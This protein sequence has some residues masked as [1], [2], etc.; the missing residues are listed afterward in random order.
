MKIPLP[1]RFCWLAISVTLWLT[2]LV[3]SAASDYAVV[4]SAPTAYANQVA[5]IYRLKTYFPELLDQVY[6][7][8]LP[9]VVGE[10]AKSAGLTADDA[11]GLLYDRDVVAFYG[12]PAWEAR[13]A[14]RPKFFEQ[15]LTE[16]KGTFTFEI[17]PNHGA[18]SFQPVNLN[19]SQRGGRPFIAFF[20]KRLGDVKIIEGA[21]LNPVITGKFILVPNPGNCDPS[22]KYRVVFNAKPVH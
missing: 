7:D 1:N 20:P 14:D 16:H 3:A 13:M 15:T 8:Q 2:P 19:G 12:D 6:D 22:K 10:A 17:R 21:D 4:V 9:M 18:E 11:R 5:L